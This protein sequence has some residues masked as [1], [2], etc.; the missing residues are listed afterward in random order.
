MRSGLWAEGIS[1]GARVYMLRRV[2]NRTF[3]LGRRLFHNHYYQSDMLFPRVT[4][5]RVVLS[6]GTATAGFISYKVQE[7]REWINNKVE[8]WNGL[9]HSFDPFPRRKAMNCL[10]AIPNFQDS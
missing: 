8:A 6:A 5:L 1:R 3:G 2:L 10:L 9:I 7:G 4:L